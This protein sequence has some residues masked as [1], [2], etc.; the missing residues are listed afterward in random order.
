[1]N[2]EPFEAIDAMTPS[3]AMTHS[4]HVLSETFAAP[5]SRSLRPSE[6]SYLFMY[7]F[8]GFDLRFGHAG[9]SLLEL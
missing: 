7:L 9:C 4:L 8:E 6:L 3:Q 1:V 2:S 5:S